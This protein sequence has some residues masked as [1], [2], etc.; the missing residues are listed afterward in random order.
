MEQKKKTKQE[1]KQIQKPPK[2]LKFCHKKKVYAFDSCPSLQ[3][4]TLLSLI[5]RK[6]SVE[7]VFAYQ[8]PKLST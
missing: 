2:P 5:D 1:K 6:P 8:P 4:S 3:N 7:L